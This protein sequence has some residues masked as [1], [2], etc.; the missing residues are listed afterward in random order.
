MRC[1]ILF[2]VELLRI[3]GSCIHRI[4][5][6]FLEI[7]CCWNDQEE[8]DSVFENGTAECESNGL[9][10]LKGTCGGLDEWRDFL[11]L[12]ILLKCFIA[13]SSSRCRL[14]VVSVSRIM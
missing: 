12:I 8:S 13:G 7:Y 4:V 9:H 1:C 11:V 14:C 6:P 5:G 3:Q 2:L 10:Y